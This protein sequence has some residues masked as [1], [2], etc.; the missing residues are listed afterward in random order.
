MTFLV[1]VFVLQKETFR[2]SF[3]RIEESLYPYGDKFVC[4]PPQEYIYLDP[5][6][7]PNCQLECELCCLQKQLEPL[8]SHGA[9]TM[10]MYK[11]WSRAPCCS[12]MV[13]EARAYIRGSRC[14]GGVIILVLNFILSL[15]LQAQ[16]HSDLQSVGRN[17]QL[18]RT[19]LEEEKTA[20]LL[21]FLVFLPR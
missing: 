14:S 9:I 7:S 3:Y 16:V 5:P 13:E 21:Y 8:P 20:E 4:T 19:C 6:K 2:Y 10:P 12:F 18:D 11:P 15:E 17:T 1:Q